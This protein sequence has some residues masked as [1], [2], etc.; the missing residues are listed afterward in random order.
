MS[1]PDWQTRPNVTDAIAEDE[2]FAVSELLGSNIVLLNNS[3]LQESLAIINNLS[4]SE[5]SVRES[6]FPSEV[7]ELMR[8]I[9][10]ALREHENDPEKLMDLQ[11]SL[12]NSYA[13]TSPALRRAWLQS[14]AKTHEKEGNLSE[15]A[16]C[17]AHIAGLESEILRKRLADGAEG[18]RIDSVCPS[19][20]AHIS[21]NIPRDEGKAGCK[22][23][24]GSHCNEEHFSE[25]ILLETLESTATLFARAERFEVVPEVYKIMIPIQERHRDF[26]A[27]AQI[28]KT[29]SANYE[30]I[31]QVRR[32]GKR[33]LGRYYRV[34]FYGKSFFVEES[35][36]EFVYKEPKVT[37]LSEI[38]ERLRGIFGKKFG[39]ENI[40]L[41]MS[42]KSVD[43]KLDCDPKYAY[44]QL[45]HVHPYSH[46]IEPNDRLTDFEKF[47]NNLSKFMFETPFS[48][49]DPGKARS[50]S[51]NDQCKRRTVL[52]TLYQFPYVVKRIPVI[53]KTVQVLSPIEVA[54]DEMESR[55]RELEEVVVTS[56]KPD[57]KKLQLKLQGSISVQVN[58]GPLAYA[59]AFLSPSSRDSQGHVFPPEKVMQLKSVFADFTNICD[60]ALKLNEK[61]IASD[62]HEYQEALRNS[63]KKMDAELR[64]W[65][66]R[67]PDIDADTLSISSQ[68]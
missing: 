35:G 49:S 55:I 33:I 2:D 14:M 65:L 6:E 12:A 23:C 5:K 36:K 58:A 9:R 26:D 59:R 54:I 40:R 62:Q 31:L 15:A 61:L 60:L 47:D 11:W 37:S 67:T 27:L 45:T 64:Q 63:F 19:D 53:S 56:D 66:K 18:Q 34:A 51:C 44:I 20:F 68:N 8:K 52:T 48:L 46:I 57:L 43:E 3:R 21:V 1:L 50:N 28:Y 24:D 13:E 29:V 32:S 38:S 17:F 39:P 42:E 22:S 25:S 41:I 4:S 30:K 10:T 7:R 16:H